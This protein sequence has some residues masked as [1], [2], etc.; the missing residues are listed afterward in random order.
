MGWATLLKAGAKLAGK[1]IKAGAELL[2]K[3][4]KTTA[5]AT[6]KVVGATAEVA[7]KGIKSTAEVVGKGAKGAVEL[8]GKAI[9]HPA[10]TV[11]TTG[12]AVKTL[13]AGGALGYVG[14]QKLTS[15][16]SVVEIVSDALIGEKNTQAIADTVHGTAEGIREMRTQVGTMTE[17]VTSTMQGVDSK[18]NGISNF[19]SQVSGGNG[20]EMLGGFFNNLTQG[21]IKG[22]GIMGLV[23]SAFLLFGR[24]GWIGKL[25]GAVL[26]MMTIGNNSG[27]RQQQ[28]ASGGQSMSGGYQGVAQG[29]AVSSQNMGYPNNGLA[30]VP[31]SAGINTPSQAS[32]S[33][34]T[35]LK[36]GES[37]DNAP[38]EAEQIHRSRR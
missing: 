37:I 36:P 19:I 24:F 22:M 25:A 3:A 1:G 27:V 15:D 16:D 26:A 33:N 31:G 21:N 12:A 2:G 34:Q 38:Q 11:K 4:A 10:K 13:A 29:S 14:W 30:Q 35:G 7:A 20:G 8:T 18:L 9:M 6:G 32:I 17:S 28:R 5:S 23:L